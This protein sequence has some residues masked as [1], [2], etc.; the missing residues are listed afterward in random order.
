MLSVVGV[1]GGVIPAVVV[2]VGLVALAVGD[3]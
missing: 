1:V 3:W 2:A